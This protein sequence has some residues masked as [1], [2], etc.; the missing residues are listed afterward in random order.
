[1]KRPNEK[2]HQL[3]FSPFLNDTNDTVNFK[4]YIAIRR[5]VY[6]SCDEY[7]IFT[8]SMFQS[9]D[10]E[11]GVSAPFPFWTRNIVRPIPTE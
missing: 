1:M 9:E 11:S 6:V 7:Y 4:V 2:K 5:K 8:V 10:V 3:I